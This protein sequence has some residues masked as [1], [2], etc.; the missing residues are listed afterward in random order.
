[1]DERVMV[2]MEAGEGCVILRT[3][4]RKRRSPQR[5]IMLEKELRELEEKKRVI[6]RDIHSFADVRRYKSPQGRDTLEITFFWLFDS[7]FGDVKGWSQRVILRY[8]DFLACLES[9]RRAGGKGQRLLSREK[10]RKPKIEFKSFANLKEVAKVPLLRKKLGRF[11][12]GNFNW[13]GYE[14]IVITDDF[15]PYSFY[16]IGYTPYGKGI[17][18]GIIL[19]GQENLRKAHYG[20]HT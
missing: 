6:F 13:T 5:F 20:M 19:H 12:A 9:S 2:K 15:V 4:S 11:L 17:C 8:E 14:R 1:M 16:F 3:I 10:R 7:G 18:G